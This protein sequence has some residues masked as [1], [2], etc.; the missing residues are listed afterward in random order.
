MKLHACIVR[1]WHGRI[2]SH[3]ADEYLELMRTVAIPDYRSTPG[4]LGA[5]CLR[6]RDADVVHVFM[7]SLWSS[8]DDIAAFAGEDITLAKY[9]DFDDDFLLERELRVSHFEA[10]GIAEGFSTW[11]PMGDAM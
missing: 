3:R 11:R 10:E 6:R 2:A 1:S 9:Y 8:V 5:F 4:N 7:V